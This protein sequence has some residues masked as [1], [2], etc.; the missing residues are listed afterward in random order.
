MQLKMVALTRKQNGAYVAR[1]AI[2]A[3]VRES[4]F[5]LY[6]SRYETKFYASAQTP[7][8]VAKQLFAEWYAQREER[9]AALR[10]PAG[11]DGKH[12]SHKE[13]H[14]L[15]GE[16]YCWFIGQFEEEP[17]RADAW[18]TALSLFADASFRFV[19]SDLPPD[20][21]D[22]FIDGDEQTQAHLGAIACDWG[23][24][25][26][27]LADKGIVLSAGARQRLAAAIVTEYVAAVT[28]LRKRANGDYT[29][30]QRPGRF[31]VAPEGRPAGMTCWQL[32]EA[33]VKERNPKPATGIGAVVCSCI[34]RITS[35]C[36]TSQPSLS[37]TQ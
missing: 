33:W 8:D 5:K 2:P 31:P 13:A 35:G 23:R 6:G 11:G 19:P 9:I 22:E 14:A 21:I 30:D 1:K 17:G 16:W 25:S 24:V 32:F 20:E 18:D 36:A 37:W 12:L 28:L 4:H 26:Q 15:A 3:D 10:R 27:F 34:C 7:P 29:R